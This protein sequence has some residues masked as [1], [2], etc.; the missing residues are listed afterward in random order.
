MITIME[1]RTGERMRRSS[2]TLRITS[3]TS[4]L[5]FTS[6]PTATDSLQLI[7][8]TRMHRALTRSLLAMATRTI[9]P[10]SSRSSRLSSRGTARSS[11]AK[12]RAA[13]R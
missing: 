1:N 8:V 2:P 5:V 6:T 11:C 13:V 7:P 4:P 10:Q 3:S 9:R 12:N